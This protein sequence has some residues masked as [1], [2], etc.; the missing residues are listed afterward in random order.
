M[1]DS[2]QLIAKFKD[3]H[4]ELIGLVDQVPSGDREKVL[5]DRWSLK[6]SL[7]HLIAW[8]NLDAK[9]MIELNE[10]KLFEWIEDWDEFNEIEVSKRKNLNWDEI[11]KDFVDSG[12]RLVSAYQLLEDEMWDKK[13]GPENN[14]T[15]AKDLQGMIDHEE[16]H[17]NELKNYLQKI[18]G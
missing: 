17:I 1:D 13:F 14:I 11:Y 3:L 4:K 2:K 16:E 9:R 15:A 8:N 18:S 12:E 5:F 7:A 10:G 6:D